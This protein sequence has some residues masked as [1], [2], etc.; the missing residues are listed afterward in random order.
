M[1]EGKGEHPDGRGGE[2]ELGE[3]Q[4]EGDTQEIVGEK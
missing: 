2:E 4:R 1:R 3:V